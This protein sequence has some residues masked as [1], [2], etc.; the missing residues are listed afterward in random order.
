MTREYS[1]PYCTDRYALETTEHELVC[2][3][4]DDDGKA[5]Q[6]L[7]GVSPNGSFLGKVVLRGTELDPPSNGHKIDLDLQVSSARPSAN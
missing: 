3:V 4:F 6:R 5:M 2:M 1:N 7:I